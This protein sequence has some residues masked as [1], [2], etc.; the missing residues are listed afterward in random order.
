MTERYLK[1][2]LPDSLTGLVFG[3][4]GVEKAVTILNGPTGCKFY[5]SSVSD[6]RM[7]RQEEFDPLNF[8]ELW[9][10]G[11]PRVPC[12]YLDKK[13]YVYGSEGK[14]TELIGFI[15]S[16]LAPPLLTVVN[17]PGAA[18]IGDDLERIV[19]AAAGDIPFLT[20]ET[21][22]YSRPV[23]EG[24]S[25]ACCRL[26]R[27]LAAEQNKAPAARPR[28]NLLGLSLFH[29]NY[30]GDLEELKRDL[31]LC[32]I[33]V[34]CALACGCTPEDIR[35]L[36]AADLDLVIDPL[37]GK[38][39]ADLLEERFGIPQ[40]TAEGLPVGFQ[41]MEELMDRVCEALQG[42]G[43]AADPMP[44]REASERA[45]ARSFVFLSRTNSLTGLPKGTPFAVQGTLPEVL[46]YTRFLV[47]YFGM[48]AA[49]AEVL[50][51][52]EGEAGDALL[53]LLSENGMEAALTA[54]ILEA[55]AELVF[56]DGNLIAMLKARGRAFA[57]IE[58]ALPTLG[59][60]DVIPKT[61][62][63]IR[64]GLLLC[65]QVLNGLLY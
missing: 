37:Y 63:G 56:G 47:R 46:G 23:W 9:Y 30:E 2:I 20:V 8:P 25:E 5:H 53:S 55:P 24:F 6:S 16:E 65:E 62:L 36:P 42:M 57:G 32:G 22:G 12:T 7:I 41:A 29:R 50:S 28:V 54:D 43:F 58:T 1:N 48:T 34:N 10:F 14:L 18:L 17:S 27:L 15:K 35:R 3:F 38:A 26:I 13:D 39:A 49:A 40:L 21:P 31:A 11:Q 33:D 19:S 45:R 61:H 60:N 59:Y 51:P 4:E 52:L 64:G 44:F